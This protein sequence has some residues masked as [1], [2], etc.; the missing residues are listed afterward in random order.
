MTN[1]TLFGFSEVFG[2]PSP[3]DM[4][5]LQINP[6]DIS[7]DIPELSSK[8][9]KDVCG[10]ESASDASSDL[11]RKTLNLNFVLDNTGALPSVPSGCII[12]GAPVSL[13]ITKLEKVCVTP[14][15]RSHKK[16]TVRAV[17][18]GGAITL[19]G[20][21]TSFNYKYTLFNN[22]GLPLRASVQ[23][24][25]KEEPTT[26]IIS[27]LFQS[28]DISRSPIVKSGDTIVGFCEEFYEDK[29]YYIKIANHN[30]LSSFRKIKEGK[31]IEF[32]PIVS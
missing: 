3:I 6:E 26:S 14:A 13:S 27:R 7:F 25:I 19:Y 16:P 28:P 1:M 21:V 11:F 15:S 20:D 17:W 30:N 10:N 24:T 9:T 23:I 5:Q 8:P 32:P 18:G 31:T 22:L 4:Y 2:T 29:N 12:A